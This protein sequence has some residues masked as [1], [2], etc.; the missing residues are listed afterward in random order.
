MAFAESKTPYELLVRWNKDGTVS[1]AHVQFLESLTKDGVLI[2]E[3]V[4]DAIPV[5]MAGDADFPLSDILSDVHISALKTAEQALASA[6]SKSKEIEILKRENSV[7]AEML[8]AATTELDALKSEK[9][10]A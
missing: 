3:K 2:Y 7:N 8:V 6:N 4:G 10:K 1:G 5:S 9:E